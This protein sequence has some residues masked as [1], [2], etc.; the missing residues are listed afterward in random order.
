MSVQDPSPSARDY[1]EAL[2][3][4]IA[5]QQSPGPRPPASPVHR[6]L[7]LPV[8]SPAA[9]RPSGDPAEP[10]EVAEEQALSVL[11]ITIEEAAR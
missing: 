6:R 7:P 11:P 3:K 8:E 9:P 10:E 5:R 4:L 1:S 2:D